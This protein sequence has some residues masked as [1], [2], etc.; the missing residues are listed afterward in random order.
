LNERLIPKPG[1]DLAAR[2]VD[3]QL[4][5]DKIG[6]RLVEALLAIV[7]GARDQRAFEACLAHDGDRVLHR[8]RFPC[9]VAVVQ[10]G[11]EDRQPLLTWCRDGETEQGADEQGAHT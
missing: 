2:A 8:H 5:D 10:M 1:T 9:V 7:A 11:I 3:A 6:R 4:R